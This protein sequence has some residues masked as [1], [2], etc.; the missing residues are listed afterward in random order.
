VGTLGIGLAKNVDDCVVIV[1]VHAGCLHRVGGTASAQRNRSRDPGVR[2]RRECDDVFKVAEELA[3]SWERIR[4]DARDAG[5]TPRDLSR[6]NW[7]PRAVHAVRVPSA[8]AS[9][10]RT[11]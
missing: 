9:I 6:R 3:R 10:F 7:Y 8:T 2:F 5:D 1:H 11:S 4:T